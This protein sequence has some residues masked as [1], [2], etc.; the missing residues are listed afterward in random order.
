MSVISGNLKAGLP[1][2]GQSDPEWFD[3]LVQT[4]NARIE[5]ILSHGQVTPQGQWYDQAEDEF[6][7][8]IEGAAQLQIEG[9][10]QPRQLAAGDWLLLPA[11]CRHRVV[12]TDPNQPS[13]WLALHLRT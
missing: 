5:R 3:G 7:V 6:V 8:L 1:G 10:S 2:L 4:P 12:W 9:E 11:H 13:L